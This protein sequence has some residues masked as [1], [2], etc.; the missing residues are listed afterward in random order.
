MVVSE[1]QPKGVG[2]PWVCR[3]LGAQA[4]WR[5]AVHSPAFCVSSAWD[6]LIPGPQQGR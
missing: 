3:I 6:V 1:E 5:T 4:Y 2:D